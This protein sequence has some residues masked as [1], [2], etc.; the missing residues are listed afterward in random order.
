MG[1]VIKESHAT[2]FSEILECL[3]NKQWISYLKNMVYWLRRQSLSL[4]RTSA[5]FAV[6]SILCAWKQRKSTRFS[7]WPLIVLIT[8]YFCI[9]ITAYVEYLWW[10]GFRLTWVIRCQAQELFIWKR[11]LTEHY[12]KFLES[13]CG[14]LPA[15]SLRH[16]SIL[17]YINDIVCSF[18]S[19]N[20]AL[21]ADYTNLIIQ[22][23]I[24]KKLQFY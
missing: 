12:S 8:V 9:N 16:L 5:T 1:T 2:I 17:L 3:V 24:I 21:F 22:G 23:S 7:R 19:I 4:R 10:C 18:P 13:P 6:H 15:F 11:L 14:I 20:F